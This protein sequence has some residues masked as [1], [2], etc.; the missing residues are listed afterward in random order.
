MDSSAIA[1]RYLPS[2]S[3]FEKV[4]NQPAARF[5]EPYLDNGSIGVSYGYASREDYHLLRDG[6]GGS[7]FDINAGGATKRSNVVF[8][9]NASYSNIR[10]N[11]V[12]WTD[13]SDYF[14]LGPYQIVDSVG[15]DA[16]GE[17]YYL[18]GGFS[19]IRGKWSWAA[20]AGYRAGNDY[21]KK[22]PRPKT[23]VSDLF[24]KAGG[25]V[26]IGKYH[27]GL[28]LGFEIYRQKLEVNIMGGGN[29]E[30]FFAMKGFGFYDIL[31]SSYT[32]SFSWLYS[33]NTYG[34]EI[35]LLPEDGN[36]WLLHAGL[37]DG[38]VE[39]WSRQ[40]MYP[41][42]FHT[43]D[44]SLGLGYSSKNSRG[45]NQIKLLWDYQTGKGTE[46]LYQSMV[47]PGETAAEFRLISESNKYTRNL[48]SILLSG[49]R[50]W[51]NS[52][53]NVWVQLNV[54]MNSYLERYA[55]PAYKINYTHVGGQGMI[56]A[57][58]LWKKSSLTAEFSL[59]YWHLVSSTETIPTDS[60]LF[61]RSV[62]PDLPVMSA[63]PFMLG[64]K[65]NYE[66]SFI[67]NTRWYVSV[68]AT[69]YFHHS[70]HAFSATIAIGIRL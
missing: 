16:K 57:E 45:S 59:G 54:G 9:G 48:N 36:G 70:K 24:I 63:S 44:V 53:S 14:K 47:V 41:F 65:L 12:Q 51:Y 33:G 58:W 13:V 50:E 3:F 61:T 27:L 10:K 68:G 18:S 28:T 22:D 19:I 38:N 21:R 60:Y 29:N 6:D 25:S 34:A 31:Q 49:L 46:R 23:I 67:R 39:S 2:N 20:E 52:S 37:K 17:N 66:H 1:S 5:W 32:S 15:G 62:Q 35:F 11:N 40:A 26:P 4:Y 8:W 55:L 69:D 7:I 30:Y 64:G 56:G 43:L 42:N